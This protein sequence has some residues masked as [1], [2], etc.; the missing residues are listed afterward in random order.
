MTY[1]ATHIGRYRERSNKERNNIESS[2]FRFLYMSMTYCMGKYEKES[3]EIRLTLGGSICGSSWAKE[4]SSRTFL[5]F[6]HRDEFWLVVDHCSVNI[7]SEKWLRGLKKIRV[8]ILSNLRFSVLE[9]F[10][11]SKLF[12]FLEL[13]NVQSRVRKN[14]Q[15]NKLDH[16]FLG[17]NKVEKEVLELF[18]RSKRIFS[19][20]RDKS[21]GTESSLFYSLPKSARWKL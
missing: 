21:R 6:D 14:L 17:S 1:I 7:L 19:R 13:F 15:V 18:V 20:L 10:Q 2:S 9:L 11:D 8:D 5:I 3:I 12:P 4:K 16:F